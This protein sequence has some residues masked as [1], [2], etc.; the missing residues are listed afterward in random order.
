MT[1]L[2]QA[3]AMMTEAESKATT[4]HDT[5][6]KL[7]NAHLDS[8]QLGIRPLAKALGISPGYLGDIRTGR[9]RISRAFLERLEA[10]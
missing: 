8:Y 10:K 6:S 5:I 4:A 9:R 3:R 1:T 2:Q 7:V